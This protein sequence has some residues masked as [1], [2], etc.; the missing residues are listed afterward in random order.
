MGDADR[1][2]G[3]TR[4]LLVKQPRRITLLRCAAGFFIYAFFIEAAPTPGR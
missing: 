4:G 2:G 3:G 1:G